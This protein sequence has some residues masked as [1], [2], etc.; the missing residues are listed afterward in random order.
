MPNELQ[1]IIAEEAY[2]KGEEEETNLALLASSRQTRE[3]T[4]DSLQKSIG[5][6]ASP[7]AK[8]IE[9]NKKWWL[10]EKLSDK[11]IEEQVDDFKKH[12]ILEKHGSR[13]RSTFT[14]EVY[15]T[16]EAK[17]LALSPMGMNFV[18]AHLHLLND[19]YTPEGLISLAS[20]SAEKRDFVKKYQ[21]RFLIEADYGRGVVKNG[22][23][24]N[25]LASRCDS[26]DKLKTLL[27]NFPN[28]NSNS[29]FAVAR[30]Y[31]PFKK[32]FG[33]EGPIPP[34]HLVHTPD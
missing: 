32:P 12:A 33:E 4:S 6:G 20:L 5:S 15:N 25:W 26:P 19:A 31:G 29:P 34:V 3:V 18:A 21:S 22:N 11:K 24:I 10:A 28:Q 2:F 1:K 8:F 9:D 13:I 23:Y 30:F 7:V 27:K 16:H 17:F 14:E